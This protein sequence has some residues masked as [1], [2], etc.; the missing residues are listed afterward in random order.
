MSVVIWEAEL[1]GLLLGCHVQAAVNYKDELLLTLGRHETRVDTLILLVICSS[2]T[3]DP[4][5][6]MWRNKGITYMIK[7]FVM[8]MVAPHIDR[9]NCGIRKTPRQ[10]RKFLRVVQTCNHRG[11]R[12]PK[13]PRMTRR[14]GFRK[15]NFAVIEAIVTIP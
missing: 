7:R 12:K 15:K 4:G 11:D 10:E 3:L 8:H 14:T 6:E 13:P 1:L 9:I 5:R 2:R